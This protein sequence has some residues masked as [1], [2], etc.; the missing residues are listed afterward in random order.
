[1][2]TQILPNILLIAGTGRDS[3][4]TTFA[5]NIIRK[6][7][8]D[9]PIVAVKISA[10]FHEDIH[11]GNLIYS[12]EHLFVGEETD[13]SKEKDS[14]RMLA[15]GARKSFFI[16][17]FDEQ[18]LEAIQI[19]QSIIPPKNFIICESGG[20][21]NYITPGLFFMLNRS[22]NPTPKPECVPYK[23][24]CDRWITFDGHDFDFTV[25]NIEIRD[26]KWNLIG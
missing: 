24:L 14:S 17:A 15:A 20:L 8:R 7:Y 19:V 2:E 10:H 25:D 4:K 18:V 5:C 21:R 11:V 6:F 1:M 23:N 9:L 12:D 26:N 22:D 13:T 3:G 16:M